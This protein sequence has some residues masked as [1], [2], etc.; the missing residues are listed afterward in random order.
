MPQGN[1]GFYVKDPSTTPDQLKAALEARYPKFKA[2]YRSEIIN[3]GARNKNNVYIQLDQ[4]P[5]TGVKVSLDTDNMV[6]VLPNMGSGCLGFL[7]GFLEF[8]FM[9]Y[10]LASEV[11]EFL[12]DHFGETE[13][14]MCPRCNQL[15]PHYAEKCTKCGGGLVPYENPT[16]QAPILSP[17]QTVASSTNGDAPLTPSEAATSDTTETAAA[18]PTPTPSAPMP[19][20][21]P[22]RLKNRQ[23]AVLLEIIPGLF[24]LYGFGWMY[25][26]KMGVGI[27]LLIGGMIG[28]CISIGAASLTATVSCCF[29]VPVNLV[30]T[31]ISSFLLYKYA[32]Q[33]T[34]IFGP[35]R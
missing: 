17:S 28:W 8:A 1:Y 4:S 3:I 32:K 21:V 10:R 18:I 7:L 6:T 2:Y 15:Y 19:S 23:S 35:G 29:T 34:E 31:A 33:H 26:G 27:A 12:R 5:V 11:G 9:D 16:G 25:S 14:L 20:Y 30:I 13:L 24:G 22:Q